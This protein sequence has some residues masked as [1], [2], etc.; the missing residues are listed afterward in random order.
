MIIS[1]V[2]AHE[3]RP[4]KVPGLAGLVHFIVAARAA[5]FFVLTR[6]GADFAPVEVAVALIHRNAVRVAVAHDVNL[7]TGIR[8]AFRKQVALGNR[9]RTV[10]LGRDAHDLAAQVVGV[11]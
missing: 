4:A 2:V 7:V 8:G 9:I 5:S 6:V 11:G 10:G 3:Q 1:P